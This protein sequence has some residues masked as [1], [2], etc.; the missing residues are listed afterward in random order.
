MT[1]PPASVRPQS[2]TEG[3]EETKKHCCPMTHSWTP[4]D[5]EHF[6]GLVL[7]GDLWEQMS[8][9]TDTCAE[10]RVVKRTEPSSLIAA[11]TMR[12]AQH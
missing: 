4:W 12:L 2:V 5:K 10:A 1:P 11:I 6:I 9:W 7:L 8:V 3:E